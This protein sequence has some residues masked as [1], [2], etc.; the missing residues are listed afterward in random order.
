[1]QAKTNK[2]QAHQ[3]SRGG[4]QQQNQKIEFPICLSAVIVKLHDLVLNKEIKKEYKLEIDNVS[5][6]YL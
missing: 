3:S 4:F 1:M 6:Y 2:M 5:I